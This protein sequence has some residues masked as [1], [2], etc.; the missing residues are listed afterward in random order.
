MILIICLFLIFDHLD[1]S[2]NVQN[3]KLSLE[4]SNGM[5]FLVTLNQ[6]SF[7]KRSFGA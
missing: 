2:T 7:T 3:Y 1:A 5:P 4:M 6:N